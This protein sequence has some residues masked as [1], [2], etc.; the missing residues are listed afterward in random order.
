MHPVP[1]LQQLLGLKSKEVC[2]LKGNAY[3]RVDAPILL[4]KEFRKT[5]EAA[6]FEAHPLDVCMFMLRN[7]QDPNKLEG[8]LGTHVDDGIGGGTEE[9]EKAL[10]KV[11]QHLPFGQKEYNKFRLTGLDIEQNPDYSIRISQADYISRIDPI[12]IPKPRGKE[13]NSSITPFELQ[14]LRAL[15]GS[16]QYAAAH[17]RPDITAKVAFLQKRIPQ[18]IVADLMEGNKVLREAKNTSETSILVQPIPLK[19]VTFASFGDASF[20]SEQQLKAQQGLF[21]MATTDKIGKMKC[22]NSHQ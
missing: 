16:L 12:D 19:E 21:I 1:E 8:V 15:C 2:L 13:E 6:G 11:Q 17:S 22:P 10:A 9:F 5:L 3:G 4:Y 20:A 7:K 14:Q 18:A